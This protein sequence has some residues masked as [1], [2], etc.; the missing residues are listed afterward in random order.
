[1]NEDRAIKFVPDN[2]IRKQ[3]L[4]FNNLLQFSLKGKEVFS[5]H[6]FA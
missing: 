3:L 6:G 4:H 1:M 2:P 5:W